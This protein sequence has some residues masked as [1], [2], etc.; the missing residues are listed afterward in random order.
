M[1]N[2]IVFIMSVC[3]AFIMFAAFETSF[4]SDLAAVEMILS[5]VHFGHFAKLVNK[6]F[7]WGLKI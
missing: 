4:I 2:K 3:S 5:I 6:I 1:N 7:Q